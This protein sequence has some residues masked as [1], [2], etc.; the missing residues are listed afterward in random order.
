[1]HIYTHAILSTQAHSCNSFFHMYLLCSKTTTNFSVSSNKTDRF[2]SIETS[3]GDNCLT[4]GTAR[5]KLNGQVES[6]V[7]RLWLEFKFDVTGVN[8]TNT[9][10]RLTVHDYCFMS[11]CSKP[12]HRTLS[13]MN[14]IRVS[15]SAVTSCS[16][17]WLDV[18]LWLN[19]LEVI[20]R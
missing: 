7:R 6:W 1:M 15:D 11:H 16:I 20:E 3:Q 9:A 14:Y 8:L 12:N 10:G 5:V 19:L 13:L 2:P 4:N 17:N 18:F